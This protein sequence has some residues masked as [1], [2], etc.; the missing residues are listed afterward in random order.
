MSFEKKSRESSCSSA[1][2]SESEHTEDTDNEHPDSAKENL[3]FSDDEKIKAKIN[4][5]VYSSKDEQE[6][7]NVVDP[8][9]SKLETA[10]EKEIVDLENL[11]FKEM[12]F[13]KQDTKLSD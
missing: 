11:T 6:S 10:N 2:S 3:E 9:C 1:D 5:V 8:E 7:K 12:D 13:D 4:K